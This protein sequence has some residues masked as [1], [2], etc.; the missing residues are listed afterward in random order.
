M[1]ADRLHADQPGPVRHE[2]TDVNV[3]A[4]FGFGLGLILVA[5]CVYGG[6]FLLFQYLEGREAVRIAP[7]YPLSATER[8][9]E[10]PEP[11]L[12]T[13]P[14]GDLQQLR[15]H[16]DEILRSY[17][18]VDRNAGIVRIPRDEAMKLT[19]KRGLPARAPAGEGK[20]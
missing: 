11:R 1:T 17:G 19:L 5:V 20:K 6:V 10:P 4:I 9:R 13:D 12:Q 18:W 15:A 2:A 3:R 8:N 16:E 7:M 14:R